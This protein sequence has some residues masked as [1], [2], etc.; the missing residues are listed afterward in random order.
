M[1]VPGT[2]AVAEIHT[3][4]GE[5]ERLLSPALPKVHGALLHTAPREKDGM[6]A[7]ARAPSAAAFAAW[8]R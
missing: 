6:A 8:P 2:A 5:I 3:L 7:T 1:L 4:A